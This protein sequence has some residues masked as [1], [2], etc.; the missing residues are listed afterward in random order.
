M[1]IVEHIQR[2]MVH[3]TISGSALNAKFSSFDIL[4]LDHNEAN[5]GPKDL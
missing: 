1:R 5:S 4:L 3:K 2:I